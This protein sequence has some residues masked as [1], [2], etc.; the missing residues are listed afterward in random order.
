MTTLMFKIKFFLILISF[1][2]ITHSASALVAYTYSQPFDGLNTADLNGQDSWASLAGSFLVGAYDLDPTYGG[3]KDIKG[4]APASALYYSRAMTA[5][6]SGIMY[7]E[8]KISDV[9]QVSSDGNGYRVMFYNTSSDKYFRIRVSSAGAV[10]VF[11]VT[12]GEK[13]VSGVTLADATWYWMAAE[14][15]LSVN[16]KM[17]IAVY[18]G[19]A[20]VW[21]DWLVHPSAFDAVNTLLFLGYTDSGAYDAYFDNFQATDPFAAT[22]GGGWELYDV[23]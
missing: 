15:D 1:F 4:S 6:D 20:W 18:S 23:Q 16:Y 19:G 10:G 9:S 22:G 21:S 17:R 8:T 3:T 14:F 11:E 7:F 2:F 12:A 5:W 13:V